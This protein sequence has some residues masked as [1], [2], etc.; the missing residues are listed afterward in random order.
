VTSDL[1]S[2]TPVQTPPAPP[3]TASGRGRLRVELVGARSVVTTVRASS[4]L[5]LLTPAN[6][7]H[8]AWIYTSTYGGGLVDGDDVAL[9][10]HVGRDAA[11]FLSTQ[12]STKVYRSPR[13]SRSVVRA[14][15]EAGGL[16]VSWPD[17]VVPFAEARYSQTQLID[18]APEGS[19]I[20]VDALTSG[21]HAS[22]ER[23]A[24]AEYRNRLEVRRSGN[25]LLFDALR[26]CATDGS[27]TARMGRFNAW[28]VIVVAGAS[29]AQEA[30]QIVRAAS[31]GVVARSSDSLVTAAV[32]G[33]S[34]CVVRVASTSGE[35]A[36]QTIRRLLACVPERLGEDPWQRKW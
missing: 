15:V 17:P 5:R 23:W 26:L 8:A 32:V 35:E 31:Q 21:R 20:I 10:V 4:P 2:L 3:Q 6:H 24:F 22:G 13:G 18:L 16:L 14:V 36:A 28:A 27:L 30:T 11:A 12:A 25:L 34:A 1:A 9:D 19:V 29:L 33:E 7:G